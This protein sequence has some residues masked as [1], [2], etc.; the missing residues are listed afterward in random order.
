MTKCMIGAL[1]G[2]VAVITG[3]GSG[4]GKA[5]VERFL[6]E[7]ASCVAADIN[8]A[9]V[10][11]L[12]ED[13]SGEYEGKVVS[14]EVNVACKDQVEAMIDFCIETYGK[15]D[16]IINNA[17]IMDN[18]LPIAELPD[19]MWDRIMSINLDSVMYACR[20]SVR[21]FLETKREGVIINT[22]SLS[23][24]CAGRGGLAYTTSKFGVVGLT[25]NVAFMYSD[26]G[27]RCNA[28]CPGSIESNIGSGMREPSKLG[29]AKAITG[30]AGRDRNGSADEVATAAIFLA[31][32][33]AS[34]I[35]GETLTIDGGWSAY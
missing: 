21:Y 23:G 31:S 7:G 2:K 11:K 18:L 26:A 35:N 30:N 10:D 19:E 28:L 25:K 33:A 5:M 1:V 27:I 13:L 16:I 12:V 4:I 20:K 9:S 14:Y 22:A 6:A 3:G 32:D 29:L 24:L 17:G 34:F 15:M 8:K